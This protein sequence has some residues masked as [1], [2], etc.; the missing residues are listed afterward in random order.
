MNPIFP[1]TRTPE[2]TA[3]QR[4][5]VTFGN[6]R[7]LDLWLS[8]RPRTLTELKHAIIVE[9]TERPDRQALLERL[10]PAYLKAE[11]RRIADV[12]TKQRQKRP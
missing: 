5:A 4:A 2:P 6:R 11:R 12:I 7:V 8:E 3:R 10:L 1:D 9:A